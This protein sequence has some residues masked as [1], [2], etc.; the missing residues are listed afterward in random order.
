MKLSRLKALAGVFLAVVLSAPAW[1]ANPALPGTVNYVEG[2]AGIGD[3][4]L[5]AKSAGSAILQAGQSIHTRRG[6]VEVLLTPGVFVRLGNDS[7]IKMVSP[8]LTDTEIQ[9]VTGH[10]MI[11]ADQVSKANL[12]RID[13]GPAVVRLPETG[14]YDFDIEHGKVRV[15]KG[16][17]LVQ[18]G[19]Q[20]ITVKGG[21][22]LDLNSRGKLAAQKFDQEANQGS[23]YRFTKLRSQ[24]LA[25]ASM[26]AE[27]LYVA[28]GWYGSGWYGPGWCWTPWF[29]GYTFIPA[30]GIFYSPFGWGFYSPLVVFGGPFYYGHYRHF[31]WGPYGHLGYRNFGG[32]R[33][34]RIG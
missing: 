1:G 28:R 18:D 21:R 25:E 23:L 5:D 15:F 12:I 19:N 14:L 26:D 33:F 8:S 29:G 10:T 3:Q 13:Q 16:Q 24:Y 2:Q 11:E 22:E 32:G 31:G 34:G 20:Q 27:R 7:S 30:N 9:V 17:A 4:T 6:M